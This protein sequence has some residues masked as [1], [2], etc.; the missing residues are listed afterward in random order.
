MN[1]PLLKREAIAWIRFKAFVLCEE[2]PGRMGFR[3]LFPGG[4][5]MRT[6]V[7]LLSKSLCLAGAFA[8][9]SAALAATPPSAELEKAIRADLEATGGTVFPIGVSNDAYAKW[10]TGDT[11]LAP[12]ASSNVGVSNV[13][14]APGAINFWHTHS[15]SCQILVGVSGVGYYQIW[16]EEPQKIVAGVTVTIPEGVKHWHGAS[17]DH[18]FQHLA[19]M[20]QGSGTTWLEPVDPKEYEKLK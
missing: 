3:K 17:H 8:A 18:W 14:F 4:I 2:P 5:P 16:G 19:V 1:F 13:T 12:L 15:G 11:Y 6:N 7:R 10:F 20:A 9:M